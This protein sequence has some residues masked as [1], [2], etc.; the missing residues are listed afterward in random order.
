MRRKLTETANYGAVPTP[1][2]ATIPADVENF[3]DKYNRGMLT[4][5]SIVL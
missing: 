5:A 3:F 4:I 1:G 2:D